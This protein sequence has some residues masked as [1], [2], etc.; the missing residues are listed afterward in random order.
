MVTGDGAHLPT[1]P[2]VDRGAGEWQEAKGFRIYLADKEKIVQLISWHQISDE[3][4]FYEALLFASTLIPKDKVRIALLSDGAHRVQNR[5]KEVFPE[6]EE[7]LDYYH[8]SEHIH[9][10]A[11]IQYEDDPEKQVAW[12]ESTMSRLYYGE[13]KSV[14]HGLSI[15]K[16]SS[17]EAKEEIRKLKVYLMN[18]INRIDYDSASRSQFPLG[19]GAIES[20]NKFICHVRMKRSGTWWYKINGN[21]MLRIRCAIANGN[22][23][24]VFEQ[25]KSQKIGGAIKPGKMS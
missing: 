10:L 19:S 25:Y 4:E 24:E 7:V 2:E 21:K 20:A 16:P 12:I 15:M 1:R 23:D 9:T 17:K 3:Q 18:N 6:G 22:F 14:V 8:C 11:N 13:V 5:M